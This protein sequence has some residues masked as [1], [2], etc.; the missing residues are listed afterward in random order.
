MY[1]CMYNVLYYCVSIILYIY[2]LGGQLNF[3]AVIISTKKAYRFLKSFTMNTFEEGSMHFASLVWLS[4][5]IVY[6]WSKTPSTWL[7]KKG[8]KE[9][10]RRVHNEIP[11]DTSGT[12]NNIVEFAQNSHR[13]ER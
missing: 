5:T 4:Q 1:V 8:S 10:N 13:I 7:L 6:S 12:K 9:K 2:I 3:H 11:V